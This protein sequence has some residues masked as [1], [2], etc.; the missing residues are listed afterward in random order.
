MKGILWIL[1][2][3]EFDWHSLNIATIYEDLL[4]PPTPS[5]PSSTPW[6]MDP[7][8]PSP[9]H[10]SW[11]PLLVTSGGITGDMFKL[12]HFRTPIP[13]RG[14]D[15]WW[16]L[17]EVRSGQQGGTNPTGTLT[18][19]TIATILSIN[20]QGIGYIAISLF[21]FFFSFLHITYP[22]S[23]ISLPFLFFKILSFL[24]LTYP[25]SEDS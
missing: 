9:R 1:C 18:T 10:V 8:T 7:R 22:E 5:T 2:F 17:K 21:L 23:A 14:A 12:V 15:I 25:E 13:T 6:T 20:Y 16:L 24:Q 4:Q 3:R 11:E 19:L